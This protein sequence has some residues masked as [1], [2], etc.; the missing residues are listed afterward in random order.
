MFSP[1]H[2]TEEVGKGEESD[3]FNKVSGTLRCHHHQLASEPRLSPSPQTQPEAEDSRRRHAGTKLTRRRGT[4]QHHNQAKQWGNQPD[5]GKD[6]GR[7]KP[8]ADRRQPIPT[9]DEARR[10]GGSAAAAP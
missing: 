5:G 8:E 4:H 7:P 1:G 9:P 2:L 6:T 10:K 3:A